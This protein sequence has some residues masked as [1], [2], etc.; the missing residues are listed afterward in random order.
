MSKDSAIYLIIIFI[1]FVVVF[2]RF[3]YLR[4]PRLSREKQ[5]QSTYERG[6]EKKLQLNFF[7]LF[8]CRILLGFLLFFF[9]NNFKLF[10][11]C[12]TLSTLICCC[13]CWCCYR[14]C[15][16]IIL[17]GSG[18][19]IFILACLVT[20]DL[21]NKRQI[22]EGKCRIAR[23]V[24]VIKVEATQQKRRFEQFFRD[25]LNFYVAAAAAASAAANI[26]SNKHTRNTSTAL[27]VFSNWKRP[28]FC[29]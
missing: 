19:Y 14:C 24:Y 17:L 4:W 20:T 3:A 25:S 9:A 12:G 15:C 29:S 18:I 2:Y 21:P 5:Q 28:S 8:F 11:A 26:L 1:V 7:L 10:A 22:S 23:G 13:C 16:F 27:P 6:V